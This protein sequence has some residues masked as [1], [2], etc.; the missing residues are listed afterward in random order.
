[1]DAPESSQTC[2]DRLGVEY[3][4]RQRAAL[5]PADNIGPGP[6]ACEAR[7]TDHYGR[8]VAV[9]SQS[10]IDLNAWMVEEGHALA[11]RQYSK[12]YVP[13]WAQS[14]FW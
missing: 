2:K 8:I 11:Y 7:D 12:D 10:G 13:S 6:V 3:R 1:M 9:C 5:A 4:C 14:C